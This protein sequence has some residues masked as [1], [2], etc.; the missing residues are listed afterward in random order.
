MPFHPTR[1]IAFIRVAALAVGPAFASSLVVV[2]QSGQI[3]ELRLSGNHVVS[4]VRR[5]T[6]PSGGRIVGAYDFDAN[7]STD[8]V[9]QYDPDGAGP[10]PRGTFLWRFTGETRIGITQLGGIPGGYTEPAGTCDLDKDGN[11]EVLLWNPTNHAVKAFE[12]LNTAPYA[13]GERTIIPGGQGLNFTR[14]F[15]AGDAN[16]DG[17]EDLI[18]QDSTSGKL[19]VRYL[20]GR[21]TTAFGTPIDV[22]VGDFAVGYIPAAPGFPNQWNILFQSKDGVTRRDLL[23]FYLRDKVGDSYIEDDEDYRSWPIVGV[24]RLGSGWVCGE[25]VGVGSSHSGL[26]VSLTYL[27][28]SDSLT[29]CPLSLGRER[30]F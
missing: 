12:I 11:R 18:L 16:G 13:G 26:T 5:G 21:T 6:V 19:K 22:P 7:G 25:W 9:V 3:A 24:V 30:G 23:Q 2:S 17:L 8:L 15:A 4:A 20:S 27:F 14:V 29:P 28:S 1:K 10:H